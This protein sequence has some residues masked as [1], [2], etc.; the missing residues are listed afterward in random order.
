MKPL[1]RYIISSR[2]RAIALYILLRSY[3]DQ[4]RRS[5][6]VSK[7]PLAL[8]RSLF[9]DFITQSLRRSPIMQ[10]CWLSCAH[11]IMIRTFGA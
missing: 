3:H 4:L 1:N 9:R 5:P 8:L 6:R 11:Y 7:L 2:I 10:A